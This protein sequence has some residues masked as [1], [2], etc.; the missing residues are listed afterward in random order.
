MQRQTFSQRWHIDL[1]LLFGLIGLSA[2]GLFVLYSSGG[3]DGH[4]LG[5][6]VVRMGVAFAVMVILA[7]VPPRYWLIWSP[8]LYLAV[9]LLLLVVATIGDQAQ[10]AQRWISV[11]SIQFQPSELAKISVPLMVACF[12]S[13]GRLPPSLLRVLLAGV[14]VIVPTL[15]IAAQPDL[16]T[17]LLIASSG[18]FVLFLAGMSWRLISSLMLL[19]LVTVPILWHFFLHD[20]QKR[21]VLT[22]INPSQDPLGAGYHI[23]QSKIAIGSGGI[24]GKGWRNGT[25]SQLDFIPERSTDFI[26]SVFSEEFGLFG[27][28]ILLTIYLFVVYRGLLIAYSAQD[29]FGRLVGGGFV[30]TF[31]VYVF[32]NMGMVSGILPVV[33]LPLPL[34]SYGGSSILTMMVGFGI[35]MSVYTHRRRLGNGY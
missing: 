23:I 6:Q 2:I 17:S 26:F 30:L 19:G 20:Y 7:Q 8:W 28:V 5:R 4:L 22:F 9:L 33:G 10:G 1:P 31:F 35:L 3:S 34:L 18:A 13:S 27:V 24:F 16:G 14:I 15:L 32:V 21:R 29:S 11:G 12:I 25:Q